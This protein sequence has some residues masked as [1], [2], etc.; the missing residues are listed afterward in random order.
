M[1]INSSCTNVSASRVNPFPADHDNSG[2]GSD[3]T[4]NRFEWEQSYI[5]PPPPYI[6]VLASSVTTMEVKAIEF[7][8]ILVFNQFYYPNKPVTKPVIENEIP[9]QININFY[10][11]LVSNS[12]KYE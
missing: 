7:H 4:K 11:C 10:K 3:V 1:T 8:R 12:S 6:I 5:R 9:V 2:K